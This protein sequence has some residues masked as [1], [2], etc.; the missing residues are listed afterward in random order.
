MKLFLFKSFTLLISTIMR[1]RSLTCILL[2]TVFIFALIN[3]GYAESENPPIQQR[4]IL[5]LKK[6]LEKNPDDAEA[7]SSLGKAYEEV[8][9]YIYA[10]KAYKE[11]IRLRSGDAEAH[12][13][14]GSAYTWVGN[15]DKAIDHYKEALKINP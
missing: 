10:I 14:I 7:H 12:N 9:N 6:I 4:K 1:L 11:V 3:S 15:Y 8:G 5:Q 13:S 2:L